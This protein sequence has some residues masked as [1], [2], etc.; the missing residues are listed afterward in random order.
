MRV[1]EIK[2]NEE[3]VVLAGVISGH[4]YPKTADCFE[5]AE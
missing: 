2:G 4:G 5:R 3:G 1:D